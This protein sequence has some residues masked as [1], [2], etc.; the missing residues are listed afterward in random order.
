MQQIEISIPAITQT[1]RSKGKNTIGHEM[2]LAR[3]PIW[4]ARQRAG[5]EDAVVPPVLYG[6]PF[7]KVEGRTLTTADQRLFAHLTTHYVRAGC[8]ADRQVPFS[9][10]EAAVALG[11]ESLGGK[12]RTLIRASLARLRSVTIESAVRHPDGHE[13]V[14]GWG[15]IDSYLVT[16]R[17]G[18]RGWI[19]LSEPIAL[20]LREGS[21]TF[22][23]TPTW[24]AIC[25]ED[26]VAGRLWSFLESE[27]VG[28]GWRYVVFPAT[29]GPAA[30][31]AVPPIADVLMLHWSSHRNVVQRIREACA[32]IESH[33]QRYRLE[34]SPARGPGGWILTCSRAQ[35]RPANHKAHG[36][37]DN[38]IAG[39][40]S[41]YRSQLPSARQR[42]ILVELLDRHSGEWIAA[43]L[44][45]ATS[46]GREPFDALLEQDRVI[47]AR[48]LAAAR[49]AEA[50]W[51]EEKQRQSNGAEQSLA[52]LIVEVRGRATNTI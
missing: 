34:L 36:I 21:V 35:H 40:R 47:S 22:L 46:I 41:V 24:D 25:S 51:E 29:D 39:W 7:R 13:T 17:G 9:L 37:P 2:N 52:A 44:S 1:L 32:V 27:N 10:G 15:F 33:D 26:A 49:N 11:H 20:L 48:R 38:V 8:P 19:V 4:Q 42:G 30:S 31:G 43:T 16:T 6:R 18:G 45:E 23:H 14:L 12:Q 28:R 50:L 5:E 3:S